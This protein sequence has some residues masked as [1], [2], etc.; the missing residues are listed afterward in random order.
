[1]IT[2]CP[3]TCL[4]I[5]ITNTIH[6]IILSSSHAHM[7][8]DDRE[9]QQWIFILHVTF[10]KKIMADNKNTNRIP[11]SSLLVCPWCKTPCY[12]TTETNY[13]YIF[14]AN[15]ANQ[16]CLE[17][18]Y[19][20]VLCRRD[21]TWPKIY[22]NAHYWPNNHQK[23]KGHEPN[24]SNWSAIL[25]KVHSQLNYLLV[26]P[27]LN[28]WIMNY[29]TIIC[30]RMLMILDACCRVISYYGIDCVII[31]LMQLNFIEMI[32]NIIR[33]THYNNKIYI[34]ASNKNAVDLF[35]CHITKK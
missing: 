34:S 14:E 15:C 1:M 22:G 30:I 35:L 26:Y 18:C 12:F 13:E 19:R 23:S 11:G 17:K 25:L 21:Q 6:F 27:H 4:Q 20:C 29:G 10:Y 33:R 2:K 8:Y 24:F 32:N 7:I 3:R 9:T 28:L 16:D 5:F 31:F